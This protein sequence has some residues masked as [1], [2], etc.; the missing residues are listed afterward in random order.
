[1]WDYANA[2][3]RNGASSSRPGGPDWDRF[4]AV[5]G[6]DAVSVLWV[7]VT[8]VVLGGC[9][10]A[11][12]GSP[13]ARMSA[14]R[15]GG[16]LVART[17]EDLHSLDP[18]NSYFELEYPIIY[19]TQ[20]P[21]YSVLPGAAERLMPD[22]AA[23]PPAI[24]DYGMTVTVRIRRGIRFSPPVDREVTSADV[25]YAIERGANPHV[26]NPYFGSYFTLIR[27]A[28][29]ATGGP[30]AGIATPNP[31][32]IVFHLIRPV[33]GFFSRAL[34]LPLTAPVPASYARPF[35]AKN[36]SQYQDYE[37]ATGPYMVQN[38]STGRVIGVG[39]RP[40]SSVV[41]V[42][43]PNWNQRTDYRPAY[44]NRI[45][46]RIGGD[47]TSVARSVLSGSDMVLLDQPPADVLQ[48]ARRGYASQ[49]ALTRGAGVSFI[50]LNLLPSDVDIRRALWA[51]LD[52]TAMVAAVGGPAA[53]T[54][55][56]HFLYPGVLGFAQA[57]GLAGPQ[58]P[59]N[60]DP[61]GSI[62][63][64]RYYMR[65]AGY[66]MGRFTGHDVFRVIGLAGS[67]AQPA[68]IVAEAI[69]ALGFQP[70]VELSDDPDHV[71]D[72]PTRSLEACTTI[73]AGEDFNDPETF[74]APFFGEYPDRQI[75]SAI[76]RAGLVNGTAARANAW[77][78]VDR[79]LVNQAIAIPWLFPTADHI[80]S[81]D[82]DPAQDQWNGGTW[83]FDFT[84]VK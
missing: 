50:T 8:C 24:S 5:R 42:R 46:I 7:A 53:G 32:T 9:G 2:F 44:L 11:S 17:L 1:V 76:A 3:R 83:D 62:A 48:L 65:L 68:K 58:V 72:Q 13:G 66:P 63:I 22:L 75:R 10:V 28:S 84:Y 6:R 27:G 33:A 74:I 52:R 30:I 45:V 23:G 43:N 67:G 82:V 78:G 49:L 47:A 70:H 71:C 25:A 31:F 41:L 16:T 35:D 57:G 56:T 55:A 80:R 77:A 38:N 19:A 59:Y 21:L 61:S 26:R 15:R 64:A 34:A 14:A 20:R 40:G 69:E 81:S 51:A 4:V 18:G 79:L 60:R 73:A 39:F 37:V 54:P 36:P 29:A 12:T